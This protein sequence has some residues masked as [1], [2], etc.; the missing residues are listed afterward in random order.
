MCGVMPVGA[1][2]AVCSATPMRAGTSGMSSCKSCTLSVVVSTMAH[3]ASAIS[4]CN[5]I[6]SCNLHLLSFGY[7]V[8]SW[9]PMTSETHILANSTV[10]EN[11]AAAALQVLNLQN[12]RHDQQ[13]HTCSPPAGGQPAGLQRRTPPSGPPACLAA[14]LCL[15][16]PAPG[17]LSMPRCRT[18]APPAVNIVI[19]RQPA[20]VRMAALPGGPRGPKDNALAQ[21]VLLTCFVVEPSVYV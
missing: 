21:G 3:A 9:L 12:D 7:R 10:S 5:S 4:I 16:P 1:A 11:V 19:R 17:M 18:R 6:R 8:L 13:P 14:V 15:R 2:T 20:S